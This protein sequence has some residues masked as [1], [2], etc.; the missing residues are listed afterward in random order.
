MRGL[1]VILVGLVVLAAT[2]PTDVSSLD[3]SDLGES[4]ELVL[5]DEIDDCEHG[6][7]AV[8]NDEGENVCTFVC[9][10]ATD[11]KFLDG[12]GEDDCVS[13]C[14]EWKTEDAGAC[15]FVCDPNGDKPFLDGLS[16]ACVAGCPAAK[17]AATESKICDYVCNQTAVTNLLDGTTCVEE[18]PTGKSE[19]DKVC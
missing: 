7:K 19:S 11:D 14:P 16:N 3:V 18:C 4:D 8:T 17:T 12:T 5:L 10:Q 15:T 9:N 2:H 1:G 6:K 13:H